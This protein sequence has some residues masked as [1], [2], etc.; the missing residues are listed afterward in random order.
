MNNLGCKTGPAGQKY[1]LHRGEPLAET[2][3]AGIRFQQRKHCEYAFV[4]SRGAGIWIQ[5]RKHC[6]THSS[7]AGEKGSGFSNGNIVSTH[8]L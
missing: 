4:I 5:Q 6:D 7:L 1:K 3:G 8:S 2:G